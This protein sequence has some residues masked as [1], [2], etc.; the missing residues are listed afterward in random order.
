[1]QLKLE[2]LSI[3]SFNSYNV[4]NNQKVISWFWKIL[5]SSK[6]QNTMAKL[7]DRFSWKYQNSIVKHFHKTKIERIFLIV[8][9]DQTC[10]AVCTKLKE[11]MATLAPILAKQ[12]RA[13]DFSNRYF[14][15]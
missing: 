14:P 5:T 4:W 9:Y 7:Q 12:D 13:H 8:V 6:W 2:F 11:D 10:D 3:K 1:M 15:G